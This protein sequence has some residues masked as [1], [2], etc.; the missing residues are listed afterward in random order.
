MH[1]KWK[2][3]NLKN[4]RDKIIFKEKL[5]LIKSCI[6]TIQT[7]YA[8]QSNYAIQTIAWLPYWRFKEIMMP[9]QVVL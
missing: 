1:L 8:I 2:N 5:Q 3:T 7:N 9:K 6:Q 4:L